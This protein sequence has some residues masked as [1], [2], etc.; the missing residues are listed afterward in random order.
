M[1]K[2]LSI[3]TGFLSLAAMAVL[4]SCL[5]DNSHYVD[6][7]GAKPL[8]ELPAATGVGPGGGFVTPIALPIQSAAQNINLVVN[9]AAPKPLTSALTVKLEID[10][11]ALT[12]YNTAN[13]AQFKSDSTAA[14]AAG[15]PIPT[16]PT[17]YTL[18]PT[19]FYTL[20]GLSVTIPANQNSANLVISVIT[21]NFD[22]TKNYVIPFTIIDGG[23]QQISNYKTVFYFVQPKNQYDGKY[24]VKGYVHRDADLAL[25][26]PIKSGVT[27]TLTTT[28]AN[29]DSFVQSWADGSTAGGINPVFLTTDPT[30]GAVTISSVVNPTLTNFGT[31]SRYDKVN[32]VFYISFIWNGADPNHRSATDT[33]TY[34]GPR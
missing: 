21:Q 10:A 9:L 6:F 2:I 31:T 26:G 34:T 14:A 7:A 25:G 17:I 8:V 15:N 28:G 3:K 27:Y 4:S 12:A 20:S 1:K 11:N 22:L 5:K 13:I 29:S 30:T 16:A 18:M 23:G 19:N 33:L 24:A 32:K